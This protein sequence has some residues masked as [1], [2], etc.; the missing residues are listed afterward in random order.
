MSRVLVFG[1]KSLVG[2]HFVQTSGH[3]IHAAGLR[4]PR[5]FG[6][7]VEGFVEVDMNSPREAA[8]AVSGAD[9]DAVVNFG[10]ATDVDRV[11]RERPSSPEEA[12]G[13]AYKVNVLAPAAMSKAAL[14]RGLPFVLLSTDFVFDGEQGPYAESTPPSKWSPLVSWYGWTK[15]RGEELAIAANPSA[16]IVRISYPYRTDYPR[17]LDF[18]RK[19]LAAR[20]QHD[21]IA[22]FDDQWITPTWIPDVT[23]ALDAILENHKSGVFHVA[24]PERTTPFEFA[25]ELVTQVEGT[26]PGLSPGSMEEFLRRP[27]ATPRPRHG[28][29]SCRRIEGE[30]VRLTPWREGVRLLA[31]DYAAA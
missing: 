27:G 22:Y 2:S 1:A 28:G 5:G 7:R 15:G 14:A 29:L 12:K 21:R 24:S 3:R 18:G 26:D 9:V 19:I 17:K 30:G 10:A 25:R 20:R 4:D 16:S 23:R 11:E 13:T 8:S 6:V 31:E